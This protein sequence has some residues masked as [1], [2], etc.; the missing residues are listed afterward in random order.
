M[1]TQLLDQTLGDIFEEDGFNIL[2]NSTEIDSSIDEDITPGTINISGIDLDSLVSVPQVIEFS[3]LKDIKASE[4]DIHNLVNTD[5]YHVIKEFE[6]KE[7]IKQNETAWGENLNKKVTIPT[8]QP[9]SFTRSGP[10]KPNS[11]LFKSRSVSIRNPRK[12]LCR[13]SSTMSQDSNLSLNLSYSQEVLPDL[14][15]IL[16]QKASKQAEVTAIPSV[17]TS[18]PKTKEVLKEVD[19][20][21]LERTSVEN[22]LSINNVKNRT[23]TVKPKTYGLGNIDIEKLKRLTSVKEDKP[24]NPMVDEILE[25]VPDT[26]IQDD[27]EVVE[28]SDNDE[29]SY[30]QSAKRRRVITTSV[31]KET[32]TDHFENEIKFE[33]EVTIKQQLTGVKKKDTRKQNRVGSTSDENYDSSSETNHKSER[34]PNPKITRTGRKPVKKKASNLTK[35]KRG[36]VR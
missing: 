13:Q 27:D 21:W 29:E 34:R 14:E 18:L 12:S 11:S 30:R 5:E 23:S 24:E 32:A 22:G 16:T 33:E 20:G 1:K 15:T 31:P 28:G 19:I 7:V 3:N 4:K 17:S 6:P 8:K 25:Y 2:D 26:N 9:T 36:K 10:F 35:V